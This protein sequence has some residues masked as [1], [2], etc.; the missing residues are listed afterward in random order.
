MIL[1]SPRP[2]VATIPEVCRA[3]DEEDF[4]ATS[5]VVGVQDR[6]LLVPVVRLGILDDNCCA[7]LKY[8]A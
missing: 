8:R 4:E 3:V 2:D 7:R 5:F 6:A 1:G